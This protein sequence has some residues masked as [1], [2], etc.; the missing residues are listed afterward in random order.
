VQPAYI[1]NSSLGLRLLAI[2]LVAVLP[3]AV[4]SLINLVQT[5][6]SQHAELERSAM[7][8]VRALST[9]VDNEVSASIAALEILATSPTLAV[10]N[11]AGFYEEAQRALARRSTWENIT[12]LDSSG[13]QVLNLRKP[14]GEPLAQARDAA[15]VEAVA[16]TGK[17]LVTNMI[18][19]PIVGDRRFVV[20]VPVFRQEGVAYVLTAGN[21]TNLMSE[22]LA[23]QRFPRDAVVAVVDS[24]GIVI[25]R[26]RAAEDWYGKPASETLRQFMRRGSEAF[27][28]TTT[29]EGH[30]VY[31]ATA[32]SDLTGRTVA[33]GMPREVLDSP[34]MTS[35]F[36][37]AAAIVLSLAI[38]IWGS[39]IVARTV[40]RPMI[41]LHEVAR[42]MRRG[43]VPQ[44]PDT[45]IPEVREAAEALIAAQA[46]RERLLGRERELRNIAEQGSRSKDE[47]LAMLGHELRNPLA[48]IATAAS[49]IEK[50]GALTNAAAQSANGIIQRQSRHLARLL[51][52]LLDVGR[53]MTGK[54]LLDRRPVELAEIVRRA[55][56]SLTAT[57]STPSQ[58]MTV[59]LAPAWVNGDASRIEQIVTNLL[60]NACKYTPVEGRIHVRVAAEGGDAVLCVRDTGLGLEPDLLPKVFD[61][62][63]QGRRTLDRSEGGLGIGLTLVRRLVE[64]H[65]GSVAARSEGAGK[66]S[67]FEMRLP[68][69][70][71]AAADGAAPLLRPGA[72]RSVLVVEDNGDAR[73]MLKSLLTIAGHTVHEAEDGPAGVRIALAV[74]PDVALVDIGLPGF[75]GYEVAREIRAA[76]D[77]S[78]RLVALTGYGLPE[79]AQRAKSAGFD[80][81]VVK[82]VDEA[83]LAKLLG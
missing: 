24:D 31:T 2:A 15:T 6:K 52:D 38:G 5:A 4:L 39:L 11:L 1:R 7:E 69:I 74:R 25:G 46:E 54:I 27:G 12:L 8:T 57:R 40:T 59:D 51:D 30:E 48:A 45:S 67:E 82:P 23:R 53:V 81:H 64:L 76:L 65:G 18:V 9:A 60:T 13:G 41:T 32:R 36:L 44:V 49:V 83:T 58:T 63:V 17:P 79:D 20:R 78:V 72:A 34:V 16:R 68:A 50:S 62:F 37:L 70:A 33:M 80:E 71:P 43:Q 77:G 47:F 66:G 35:Y 75:D 21:R 42:G 3:V 28:V 55:V 56:D 19:T 26:S 73:E 29:L 10:D 22:M 61:L 14:F